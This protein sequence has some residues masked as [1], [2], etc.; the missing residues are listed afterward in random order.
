MKKAVV[1]ALSAVLSVLLLLPV[2]L[3]AASAADIEVHEHSAA[4]C[5]EA[6]A[7]AVIACKHPIQYKTESTIAVMI[8]GNKTH[9][10]VYSRTIYTCP[11]CSMS[12]YTLGSLLYQE[13]HHF[14]EMHPVPDTNTTY[15]RVCED[16][17]YV[18]VVY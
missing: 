17:G 14:G 4:C 9:H 8:D 1:K 7:S 13:E 2:L 16:C 18:L 12:W 6:S 3:M 15:T 5:A 10:D 11:S